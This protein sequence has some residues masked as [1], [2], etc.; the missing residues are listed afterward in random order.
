[1]QGKKTID[2]VLTEF[3]ETFEVHHDIT[4]N[5]KPDGIVTFDEFIE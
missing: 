3:L 4:H 1:V 5:W 2:E